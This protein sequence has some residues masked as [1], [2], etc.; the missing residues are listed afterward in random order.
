MPV[1]HIICPVDN[2]QVPKDECLACAYQHADR[3][4][5]DGLRHCHFPVAMLQAIHMSGQQRQGLGISASQ[6]GG[7]WRQ[8]WGERH[9]PTAVAP[10]RAWKAIHGT[11]VHDF[12]EHTVRHAQPATIQVE[13]RVY[14]M[15]PNGTEISGQYDVWWPQ[16]GRIEDYKNQAAVFAVAPDHY[17][18]QLNV[19][20]W[21]LMTG[22]YTKTADTSV[23]VV[24]PTPITELVLYSMA[25]QEIQEV[26]CPLLEF[27]EI[28]ALVSAAATAASA[29]HFAAVPRK[30]LRPQTTDF[31]QRV[32]PFTKRCLIAG[33]QSV[34]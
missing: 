22:G 16:R 26:A 14:K 20:R 8:I 19:L 7:C 15:L 23:P 13:Q 32:C 18:V 5:P 2:V 6:I 25:H 12:F 9:L 27:A 21:L 33:E 11:A 28:E 1:T 29:T 31:C 17:V 30:Y 3:P 10:L 24:V 34:H 4:S